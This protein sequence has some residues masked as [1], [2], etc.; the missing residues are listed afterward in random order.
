MWC[1]LYLCRLVRVL[2]F[3]FTEWQVSISAHPVSVKRLKKLTKKH[4]NDMEI[5]RV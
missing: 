4:E 1:V 2:L 5:C 3:S